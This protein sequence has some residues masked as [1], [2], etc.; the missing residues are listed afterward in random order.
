MNNNKSIKIKC[1][2]CLKYFS[3]HLCRFGKRKNCSLACGNISKSKS[4]SGQNG[5]SWNGGILLTMR[6][7]RSVLE[8]DHPCADSKGYVYEHRLVMERKIGRYLN[9]SELVHHKNWI[10]TDN[11][12]ENLQIISRA[13]HNRE[14]DFAG[15]MRKIKK[16][17]HGLL[18]METL[19]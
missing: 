7:Y 9:P 3:I 12:I 18:K 5:P 15:N 6:G 11:R 14:H 4:M 16:A 1:T 2:I 13:E 19:K 17:N 10:K 8:K